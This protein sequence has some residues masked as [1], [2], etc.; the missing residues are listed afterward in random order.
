M[1]SKPILFD[2]CCGLGSATKGYQRAGFYVV[3]VDIR[4]QPDYCG[5]EFVQDDGFAFLIKNGREAH[6]IEP[7]RPEGAA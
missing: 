4:E 7:A 5:D 1:T 3:G 2:I 6:A